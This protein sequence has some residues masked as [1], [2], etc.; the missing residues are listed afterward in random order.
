MKF[1]TNTALRQHNVEVHSK[2][3]PEFNCPM[4]NKKYHVAQH[5]S[6]VHEGIKP[7]QCKLCSESFSRKGSLKNHVNI[8]HEGKRHTVAHFVKKNAYIWFLKKHVK[9]IH[10][11][12]KH[13]FRVLKKISN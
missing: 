1:T 7:H 10:E 5:I 9:E 8:V 2:S 13:M 12:K 6:E 11:G 3:K 4:C